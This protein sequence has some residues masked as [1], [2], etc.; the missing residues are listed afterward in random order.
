MLWR[1]SCIPSE[2]F[3]LEIENVDVVP[4]VGCNYNVINRKGD[5]EPHPRKV[6]VDDKHILISTN[7]CKEKQVVQSFTAGGVVIARSL[8]LRF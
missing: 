6:Y 7:P 8:L 4:G 3:R 1:Q 5:N 2:L